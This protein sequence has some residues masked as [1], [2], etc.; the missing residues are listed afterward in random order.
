MVHV[1]N[2]PCL[3]IYAYWAV[4]SVFG[5]FSIALAFLFHTIESTP[6]AVYKTASKGPLENAHSKCARP[7]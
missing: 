2:A 5:T 3:I 1:L 6:C 7:A 4:F